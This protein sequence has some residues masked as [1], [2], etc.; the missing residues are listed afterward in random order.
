MQPKVITAYNDILSTGCIADLCHA[1]S[2]SIP[3]GE[4]Y[5]FLSVDLTFSSTVKII[6]VNVTILDDNMVGLTE[7]FRGELTIVTMGPNAPNATLSPQLA[8][9]SILDEVDSKLI[10]C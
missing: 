7:L 9:I 4:D 2:F 5:E 1:S 8:Q 6:D 10:L 3:V